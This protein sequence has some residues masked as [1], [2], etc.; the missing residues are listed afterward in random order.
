M[1]ITLHQAVFP[2][3]IRTLTALNAILDKAAAHCEARKIDPAVLLGYRLAPDMFDFKRQV[4]SVTD[5]AKGMAARL[6]GIDVPSYPDVE[7]SIEEL[8]ARLA[9]TIDFV[10]SITPE[11]T[12]GSEDREI[13]LKMRAGEMKFSGRD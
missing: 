1:S 13:V 3:V 11:Q 4:Q 10:S 2:S 8:K 7:V 5:N 6:A 12:E 9:R